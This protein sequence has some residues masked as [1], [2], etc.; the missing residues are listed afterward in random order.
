MLSIW[1]ASTKVNTNE[2][3]LRQAWYGEKREYYIPSV[4]RRSTGGGGFRGLWVFMSACLHAHQEGWTHSASLAWIQIGSLLPMSHC[5]DIWE[6][7]RVFNEAPYIAVWA[8]R[9][10]LWRE[11]ESEGG[12]GGCQ[13]MSAL[14]QGKSKHFV[15]WMTQFPSR[16][17]WQAS[18]PEKYSK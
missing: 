12:D 9:Q 16:S 17:N 5:R 3:S 6:R 11:D 14:K 4:Y 2:E 8:M 7:R 10:G 18:S 1:K 15:S 13:E